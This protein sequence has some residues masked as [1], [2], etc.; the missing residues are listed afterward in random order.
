MP[1]NKRVV[2]ARNWLGRASDRRP[3]VWPIFTQETPAA[4]TFA[5]LRG[6]RPVKPVPVQRRQ[7]LT[8]FAGQP[9]PVELVG[10]LAK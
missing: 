3:P 1:Q 2:F 5:T 8:D 9:A 6:Y 7:A 10:A 4:R